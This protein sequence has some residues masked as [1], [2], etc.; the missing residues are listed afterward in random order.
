MGMITRIIIGSSVYNI[1]AHIKVIP[2]NAKYPYNYDYVH[3]LYGYLWRN[4]AHNKRPAN[5]DRSYDATT[6]ELP[7]ALPLRSH[8]P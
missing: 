3:I 7:G 4:A 1:Y 6:N 2:T 8:V 5:L